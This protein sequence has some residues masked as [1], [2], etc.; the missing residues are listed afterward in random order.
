MCVKIDGQ[1]KTIKRIELTCDSTN[2]LLHIETETWKEEV[3]K[4]PSASLNYYQL[5]KLF[6]S[7][8]YIL[9]NIVSVN[10]DFIIQMTL[11]LL[12]MTISIR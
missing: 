6:S 10:E 11:T 5:R 4:C 2:I 8:I 12:T 3:C 1:I 7:E 9:S